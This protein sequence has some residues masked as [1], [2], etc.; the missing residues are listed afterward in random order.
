MYTALDSGR[1]AIYLMYDFSLSTNPLALGDEVGPVSFQ[2]GAGSIFD[3]FI[4]QGGPDTNFG[5]H[6]ASSVGGT[7]DRVRVLVNGFPFDNSAGCVEGAVGAER[8]GARPRSAGTYAAEGARRAARIG[9]HAYRG[10]I[11]ASARRLSRTRSAVPS[12]APAD[13][14]AATS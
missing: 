13:R 7:G 6:P 3:V 5:P 1:D 8:S 10:E 11:R 4:I 12:S 2:V 14:P 9:H